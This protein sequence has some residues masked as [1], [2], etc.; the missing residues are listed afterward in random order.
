MKRDVLP[1]VLLCILG[2][3]VLVAPVAGL[4]VVDGAK[5][6][7]PDG[8]TSPMIIIDS[9]LAQDGTIT[10]NITGLNAFVTGGTFT[11]DNVMTEDTAADATWTAKVADGNLTLT[12]TRGDTAPGEMVQVTFTGAGNPWIANTGGEQTVPLTAII[13]DPRETA[14]ISFI[15]QTGGLA[16]TD[17]TKITAPDGATSSVIT[18]TDTEIAENDGI[19]IDVSNLNGYVV[20][21]GIFTTDDV[22]IEDNA[23]AAIWTGEIADNTLTLTSTA[24]ATAPGEM[25]QVTFT[26]AG[27]P[28]VDNTGG[29]QNYP[30]TATRTDGLG[31]STINFAIET[32]SLGGLAIENGEKITAPDGATS[33]VITI[34]DSVIEPEGTITINAGALHEYISR[35]TFTTDNVVIEDNA[36]AAIWTGEVA[37]DILT[38]TSTA[39]ATAP[40]EMVQVT[41]TGAGGNPWVADSEGDYSVPL[42]VTRTDGLGVTTL[43]FMISI[44]PMGGLGLADGAKITETDG[45]TSPVITITN[46]E[47]AQEG[48]ITINV[49]DLHQYVASGNFTTDNVV[50]TSDAVAATWTGVVEG[51]TLTLTSTGGTTAKDETVI[52][53]FTGAIHPWVA[54]AGG[55]K[56][57]G[58]TATRTDTRQTG[59]F[60][61]V[62]STGAPVADFSASPTSDFVPATIA[63]TDRSAGSP[64][65]WN[66]EFGDGETSTDKNPS[67]TYTIIGKYT[68]N[69]TTTYAAYGPNTKT[70]GNYITVLNS[71]TRVANTTIEELTIDNCVGPQTVTV[72]TSVLTAALIN[73]SVL[74][75]QPPA[76]SGFNT[77]TLFARDVT[78][79]SQNGNLITGNLTGV[80]LVSEEISPSP[81]V[82]GDIGTKPSFNY[83]IYLSSYPCN[84]I[85]ST[86]IW[87]GV[88]PE[89]DTKFRLIASGNVPPA[90]PVGTAYTAKI[91][92]TNFPPGTPV[93]LHMSVDSSWNG[94][95]SGGPGDM[96]IW[97]I[98]D[99]GNS[100]QILPTNYRYTDP[101]NNLDYYEADSPLGLSTF[102]IS[103]LT[104]N[105]NPFQLITFFVTNIISPVVREE[106]NSASM[107]SANVGAGVANPGD[108]KAPVPE[109]PGTTAKIYSNAGG[110]I[111]QATS[112]RSTDGLAT[113]NISKGITAKDSSG[114][115]LTSIGITQIPAENLPEGTVFSFAGM[116]YDIQ[117][118]GATFSPPVSLS[119][120]IPQAPWNKEFAL[121]QYDSATGTWQVLP[122]SYNPETGIVTAQV[123]HLCHFALFAKAT[124]PI[125]VKALP[126]EPLQLTKPAISTNIG[127]IG[128][129]LS[130]LREN[131][132]FLVIVVAVIAMV[133][134]FGW[135]KRRL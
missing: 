107:G 54:N 119:F 126:V 135:W 110:V 84:A 33:P 98:S 7:A 68:V 92:R 127:M 62:I 78:G 75:I 34:I 10:I 88:I 29:P 53:T 19:I 124:G 101:V 50:I 82:S 59:A 63:F 113:F 116:Y 83:S 106:S 36:V 79:F 5:I 74:E 89:T 114:M 23:V 128:W 46:A 49:T 20:A 111:T 81:G 38:L 103:S 109:D 117:P 70:H 104:G 122:G 12:S 18:I 105:N 69:L 67:H 120:T 9:G 87:N 31:V 123:S 27:N 39:G 86:K 125:A 24:G 121:Q 72:D 32:G 61:F 21:S 65:S 15:I 55:E 73:N 77:I 6:I 22:V 40:G 43:N 57:V 90:V 42:T 44:V 17:G 129:A 30:L 2:I 13:T 133:A 60:D 48:N 41:F 80:H 64:T 51:N 132:R 47:I 85:I 52:V 99:D 108:M 130:T 58:L 56:T 71:A 102:G 35:G 76:D 112:L 91:T 95:L 134:Y 14:I 131:T 16:V 96:F 37:G 1:L 115:P 26:G 45:V 100:G 118:D 8:A 93:K 3:A 97:R 94:L 4:V 11:T 28:W 66:W 25:V